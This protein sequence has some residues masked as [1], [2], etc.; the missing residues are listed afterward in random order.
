MARL[1]RELDWRNT[2]LGD[3]DQWPRS[4]RVAVRLLLGSG[5]PMYI[6]WGPGFIQFYNDAYR[7]ILGKLKHPAALGIGTPDTFPELWEFIG[8]MFRRVLQTGQE[9]TLLGQALFLNRDGYMEECYY[10][11]SYSPIPS[12]DLG[13]VGGVFVTCSEVTGQVFEQ[14][15]LK[16]VRDLGSSD[17]QARTA[18]EVCRA[19]GGVLAENQLDIP[20]AAIYL[21]DERVGVATLQAV[22][23]AAAG[24]PICPET[25]S[26]AEDAPWPV[27]SALEATAVQHVPD[28]KSRFAQVPAGPWPETPNEA[29]VIPFSSGS[30]NPVGFIVIGVNA[31][32]QFDDAMEQFLARCAQVISG[33]LANARA[34]EDARR[35]AESLAELDR[36]KTVFFSNISHE[37]RTPLTLIASPLEDLA[38]SASM[39]AADLE[40]IDL[41]QRNVIRLQRLVNNLLD[42][43]R[44]EAGRVAAT[45]EPLDLALMT[46]ELASGFQSTFDKAGLALV[47]K[48]PPLSEP[49]YVDREMWE[50]TVLN[51]ISNAFKFTLSGSVTVELAENA[52]S[53]ELRVTDT[54]VGIPASELS[55]VF[56][57]FHRIENTPGRSYEG[58]GIGLALVHELVKIH[59]G[60]IEVTSA[61]GEGS[62][63]IVRLR[64][65]AQHLDS[66]KIKSAPPKALV[67]TRLDGFVMEALRWIEESG[68]SDAA[69]ALPVT[70]ALLGD[71]AAL[72]Q[73][74]RHRLLVVD[75]NAD[76]RFYL[77]RLLE[78]SFHVETAGNGAEALGKM[79]RG[80]P[81]LVLTDVMMPVMDGYALLNS[82]RS[83]PEITRMPVI[84]LSARAGAELEL[85]GREAGADDYITKPFSARELVARVRSALKI[86][87]VRASSEEAVRASENRAREVLERTT[88]AVFVLD[89]DW[90]FTYL[91]PNAVELIANGRDLIGKTVWSEFPGAVGSE[92]WH[93]YHRVMLENVSVDFQE[94]YPEPLDKWFEVHAYPTEAGIAVFFRDITA[95]LKAET[96][97]R[98]SEKLAAVGRMA[99]SIAHEINNPLE[100]ITNLL[101]LIESDQN[102]EARTREFLTA[103]Q[104]ELNRVSH[105]ATQTLSFHRNSANPTPVRPAELVGSV[106]SLFSTRLSHPDLRIKRQ[107]RGD[108]IIRGYP[109]ELRQVLSNLLRNALDAVGQSGEIIIREQACTH[110]RTG[111]AGVRITIADSGHGMNREVRKRLFEPFFST[112]P[113]TGT[114]L[115]LWVSKQIID[116]HRGS[117][118]ARSSTHPRHHGTVFSIFLPA[119]GPIARTDAT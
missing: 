97:L 70:D 48:A 87:E 8:P 98:Q 6:A 113:A 47:I 36:A 30:V 58:T 15:R 56:Q 35:R 111:Q 29:V 67:S 53:V 14:R 95:K 118:H 7:P 92:F 93:Q 72:P 28:L 27:R 71:A 42:F 117:I 84:M 11:F 94:Y 101:Y 80:R 34:L 41:A 32:K 88:D 13:E 43:S 81:D 99:S 16:T 60:V 74:K 62:H 9:T 59:G 76:M 68:S 82:I 24:G 119:D 18:E 64:K 102:M 2:E 17:P 96:A 57:R 78:P 44:I 100:A 50:K 55:K 110:A 52:E 103:A 65:G 69:V 4:L 3:P 91:N 90:R 33:R 1:M 104:S 51:L 37:F 31:R 45:F 5:Y 46:K 63:F 21:V 109:G 75:D 115:G 66:E 40:R 107:S 54:G 77:T 19:A 85:E 61:E 83:T 108:A 114:G 106:L 39:S 22:T 86:A 49:I 25:L 116:K 20:F 26:L 23:G 10:D 112:K 89:R 12:D 73:E 38:S 79:Q 105:I